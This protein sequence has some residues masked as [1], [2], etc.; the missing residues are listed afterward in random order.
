MDPA[1]PTDSNGTPDEKIVSTKM[2][3]ERQNQ[4]FINNL[5]DICKNFDP[6]KQEVSHNHNPSGKISEKTP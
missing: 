3:F 1:K 2:Y 4:I 6:L 5:N